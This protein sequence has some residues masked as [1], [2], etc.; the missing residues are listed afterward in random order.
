MKIYLCGPMS[1]IPESNAPAFREAALQLRLAGHN[2]ISPLEVDE[3][4]GLNLTFIDGKNENLVAQGTTYGTVLARDI[5]L[6]FDNGIEA[7]VSLEG[8]MNSRGAR[9]EMFTGLLCGMRMLLYRNGTAFEVPPAEILSGLV[10][11]FR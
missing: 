3:Q 7:I 1:G 9:L 6:L 2:V 5:K 8:W 10:F 11:S 4:E